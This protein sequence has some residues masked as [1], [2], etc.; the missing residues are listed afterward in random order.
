MAS[1]DDTYILRI[2]FLLLAPV[3]AIL[4]TFFSSKSFLKLSIAQ[5]M[6]RPALCALLWSLPAIF[7][8]FVVLIGASH[9]SDALDFFILI[10]CATILGFIFGG[11]FVLLS[12]FDMATGSWKQRVFIGAIMGLMLAI[13]VGLVVHQI[14]TG[15]GGPGG[16][17]FRRPDVFEVNLF[18]SWLVPFFGLVGAVTPQRVVVRSVAL[19][20]DSFLNTD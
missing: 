14:F 7:A 11:C 9:F 17:S 1:T 8:G 6:P 2:L 3:A 15:W 18:F 13:V 5:R 16:G 20:A 19:N 12:R 10:P 4:L